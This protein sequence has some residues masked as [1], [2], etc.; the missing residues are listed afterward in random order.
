MKETGRDPDTGG[1]RGEKEQRKG[2]WGGGETHR[3]GDQTDRESTGKAQ[4]EP[5]CLSKDG[6]QRCRGLKGWGDRSDAQR[7]TERLP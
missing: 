3:Q 4:M 2:E 6:G 1:N 7:D 5:C